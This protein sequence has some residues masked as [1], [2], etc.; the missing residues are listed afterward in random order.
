MISNWGAGCG[1]RASPPPLAAPCLGPGSP[2]QSCFFSQSDRPTPSS[3]SSGKP[4]RPSRRRDQTV[5][6]RKCPSHSFNECIS[7][8]SL[9][10]LAAPAPHRCG[11]QPKWCSSRPDAGSDPSESWFR[12]PAAATQPLH[13][14]AGPLLAGGRALLPIQPPAHRSFQT[15]AEAFV[16]DL[17]THFSE[18]PLVLEA[19][20]KDAFAGKGH[21]PPNSHPRACDLRSRRMWWRV[22]SPQGEQLPREPPTDCGDVPRGTTREIG[23]AALVGYRFGRGAETV[24]HGLVQKQLRSLSE[25][26]SMSACLL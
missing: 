20:P 6:L 17:R 14:P 12:A 21:Q 13:L 25:P 22:G 19:S 10:G 2:S 1:W 18:E 4:P 23:R 5:H 11:S 16:S 26:A 8:F 3:A 15:H 24:L 9:L 7:A